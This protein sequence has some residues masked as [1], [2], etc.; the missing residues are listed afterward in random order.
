MRQT[1]GFRE[2]SAAGRGLG[3]G[4]LE[5]GALKRAVEE[6]RTECEVM[7]GKPF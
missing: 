2:D 6:G 7:G 5:E 4:L 3:E 1:W